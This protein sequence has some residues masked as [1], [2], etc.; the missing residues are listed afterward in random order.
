MA[1]DKADRTGVALTGYWLRPEEDWKEREPFSWHDLRLQA[2]TAEQTGYEVLFVP[3]HGAWE[4]FSLLAAFAGCTERMHLGTGVVT[5][6]SRHSHAAAVAATSLHAL[7]DGRFVLGL[8]SGSG[9][10]EAGRWVPPTIHEVH[11]FVRQVRELLAGDEPLVQGPEG[12]EAISQL[13]WYPGAG[14]IPIYLAA[15]GPRMAEL[16]GE[17]ADGVLLNWCTPERVAR[18]RVEVARGAE[19]AG[20]DPGEV[21][22]AVYVRACLGHEEPHALVALREAAAPY[23]ARPPYR[24][25]FE[26]MGLG[27]EAARAARVAQGADPSEVPDALVQA[28]CLLGDRDDAIGRLDAYREAG[29]DLVVVYPVPAQEAL[30]SVLGTILV[31]AS[32]PAVE[33]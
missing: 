16:A 26:T 15:L 23:A 30:S 19:R 18:A 4:P 17:V 2:E 9:R 33:D 28:T 13:H 5:I 1:E 27:E 25:Q 14:A 6:G 31:A 3:D 12:T 32:N 20:R 21:A 8:G 7:S 24:R 22:V 29:A 11:E 10:M